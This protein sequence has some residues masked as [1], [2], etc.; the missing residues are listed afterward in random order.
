LLEARRMFEL[1]VA[2]LVVAPPVLI[3]LL[4]RTRLWWLA[5]GGL[6]GFAIYL[7]GNLGVV[8]PDESTA[9][10]DGLANL[11]L[12]AGGALITLY[13]VAAL[14]FAWRLHDRHRARVQ[15]LPTATLVA[16]VTQR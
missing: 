9:G 5:G 10:L 2:G 14:G 3:A 13:G 11:V 12:V 4:Y 1:L 8:D 16:G 15:K 7:F 6:L